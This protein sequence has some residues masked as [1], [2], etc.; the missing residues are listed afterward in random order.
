[1]KPGELK[2]KKND[3]VSYFS[4]T[5][6]VAEIDGKSITILTDAAER[7]EE[8]DAERAEQAKKK[9][10][11]LMSQTRR[12]EESYTDVVAQ[13]ERA[14]SRSK[15]AQRKKARGRTTL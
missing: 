12:T 11:E 6:G 2:I 8:I 9:A 14:L 13:M 15:I 1:M 3:S 10:Q 7:A 5:K 4:V